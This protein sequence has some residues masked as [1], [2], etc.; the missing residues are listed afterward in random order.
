M[1]YLSKEAT[2]RELQHMISHLNGEGGYNEFFAKQPFVNSYVELVIQ[3]VVHHSD[4][5]E[6]TINN[7]QNR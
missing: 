4:L 2:L 1:E 6:K 5:R 3:S 7:E